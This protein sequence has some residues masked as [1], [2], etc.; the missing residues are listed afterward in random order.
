MRSE[1]EKKNLLNLLEEIFE[2]LRTISNPR[3]GCV[4]GESSTI[5]RIYDAVGEKGMGLFEE[6]G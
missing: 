4:L 6:R 2:E 5:N 3:A 1:T